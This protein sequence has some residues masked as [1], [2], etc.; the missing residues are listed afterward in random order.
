MSRRFDAVSV[1]AELHRIEVHRGDLLLG[2][3]VF[4]FE[5]RDP[6]LQLRRHELGFADD[7]AAVAR[8]IARKEVLGQLL[9]D[10]RA[11]ALRG[12]L[13]QQRFHRHT[14]QRG[15]VDARVTAEAD[16]LGR[17]ERRD[18]R[19]HLV[20]AQADVKRRVRGKE[21]GILHVGAVLH[22][23]GADD[24]A[25]LGIDLRGEVAAGI[26]QLLERGHAPEHAQRR[27]QQHHGQE[28]ERRKRH[29]PDPFYRFRAYA[30]LFVLYHK[31]LFCVKDTKYSLK[32]QPYR[33]RKPHAALRGLVA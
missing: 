33:R 4:E 2:I 8:R 26:L 6:L 17:D 1:R 9:G 7:G 22:E 27:Q 30:R 28:R 19:R 14:R 29:T 32:R 3:I 12:V 15:D 18:D 5:G 20:P 13:Q 23:K 16:I 21:I 31:P 24:L 10:G 11:A 25:V